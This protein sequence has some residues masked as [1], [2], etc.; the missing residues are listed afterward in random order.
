MKIAKKLQISLLTSMYLLPILNGLQTKSSM[1]KAPSVNLL[2]KTTL[3]MKSR[4]HW[5][6]FKKLS[7][8][9]QICTLDLKI[10]LNTVSATLKQVLKSK[11]NLTFCF[12]H[13]AHHPAIILLVLLIAN[14]AEKSHKPQLRRVVILSLNKKI[15]MK[16]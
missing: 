2:K 11:T 4:K 5:P 15:T 8:H 9:F 10:D 16:T 6:T 12:G 3:L 13:I 7:V 1:V 14:M